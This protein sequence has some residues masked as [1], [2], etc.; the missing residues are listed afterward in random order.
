[1]LV[2]A[3]TLPLQRVLGIFE[4]LPAPAWPAGAAR[5]SPALGLARLPCSRWPSPR[6]ALQRRPAR[7]LPPPP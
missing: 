7:S 5:R 4:S 3:S 6:S 2:T 1:V